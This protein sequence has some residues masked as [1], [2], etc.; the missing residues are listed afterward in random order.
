MQK[1]AARTM[2]RRK[3]PRLL[4][5]VAILALALMIVAAPQLLALALALPISMITLVVAAPI[6]LPAAVGLA[7]AVSTGE[8]ISG[9]QREKQQNTYD[10]ICASTQGKL[11]ASWSFASGNLHRGGYFLPLA[12]A[13]RASLRLGLAALAGLTCFTLLFALSGAASFGI[14]QLRLLLLPLLIAAVY[15]SNLTQTFA[16]S[17]IIGLLVSSFDWA[18]RDALLAGLL[19]YGLLHTLP[20]VGAGL[21]YLPF[22]WLVYAPHPL[23]LLVIETFALLLIVAGRELTIMALWSALRR[24]M[25]GETEHYCRIVA[26]TINAPPITTG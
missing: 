3:A 4:W 9:I 25:A 23:A 21:V 10:L 6:W 19:A 20:V 12:W 7:G 1:P 26:G 14:V 2:P 11:K 8:I 18:K 16:L 13:T 15:G 17:H 22:R 5:L 24:R